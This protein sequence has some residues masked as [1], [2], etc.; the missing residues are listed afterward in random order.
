MYS[1]SDDTD[2]DIQWEK[3]PRNGNKQL[4]HGQS[5]ATEYQ[6]CYR[7]N[8]LKGPNVEEFKKKDKVIPAQ[9]KKTGK[10]SEIRAQ[11]KLRSV[12]V[13]IW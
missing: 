13:F 11:C 3:E 1:S 7:Y 6:R 9:V 5:S 12:N 4:G 2:T 10:I 8:I